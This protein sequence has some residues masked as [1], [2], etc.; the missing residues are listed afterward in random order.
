MA[1]P[2]KHHVDRFCRQYLQLEPS[3]D[4]PPAEYLKLDTVQELIYERLFADDALLYAPPDRYRLRTLKQLIAR[5]EASIDDWDEHAVSDN[6]MSLLPVLLSAPLPSEAASVQQK[7]Y[8]T[9]SLSLLDRGL[10]ESD[11]A[12][13]I[14]LL[15]NRSL[16][17]AGGTTGL[18]TWEAALHL[19][20]YL[21]QNPSV[22]AGKR[23]LELG[24]GTG[25]LSVMCAKYLACRHIVASDGSD[26]VINNLPDNLFLNSLQDSP[27]VTPMDVKW[28]HALVGTEDQQWNEGQSIDVV[29]GADITYDRSNHPA[30][31]GTILDL[32]ELHPDVEVYIGAT[33]RNEQT[34]QVF[35]DTCKRSGLTVDD[36]EY[37][38]MSTKRQQGPFYNDRDPIHIYRV[39]RA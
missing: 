21:C 31:V 12:P 23:I 29:L 15:E 20:Q 34:S 4:F 9:Y 30:L 39:S 5:I 13:S 37:P 18:R 36:L 7:H 2:W 14:T 33:Q 27:L 3:L 19:G 10:G 26:D 6:L 11:E 38:V 17:S 35:L 16:I 22:V 8:V 24:A 28:G 32:F 1:H 25:Y